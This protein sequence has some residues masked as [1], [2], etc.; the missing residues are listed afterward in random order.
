M[1]QVE[2][3]TADPSV[4]TDAAV[5]DAMVNVLM[6]VRDEED[7]VR[8]EAPM[9]ALHAARARNDDPRWNAVILSHVTVRLLTALD[10]V[11]DATALADA[12][13]RALAPFTPPAPT[14][15]NEEVKTLEALIP[16]GV[17][18]EKLSPE[19]VR[20]LPIGHLAAMLGERKEADF[21]AD[22]IKCDLT[23]ALTWLDPG[24]AALGGPVISEEFNASRPVV[25]ARAAAEV[26]RWCHG[27]L[28]ESGRQASW[29]F[30][31]V[32]RLLASAW[33]LVACPSA[34]W[35][36]R[37]LVHSAGR[38]MR[39]ALGFGADEDLLDES[40]FKRDGRPLMLVGPSHPLNIHR[41]WY[42]QTLIGYS[43]REAGQQV[44]RK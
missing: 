17:E 44:G 4:V 27:Q 25:W 34:N 12:R 3:A 38:G 23:A 16:P 33:T 2:Q 11:P 8:L 9:R 32:G 40:T 41:D 21:D 6:C 15:T 22:L 31:G 1:R 28:C 36:S 37:D 18:A 14:F 35:G 43:R 5:A 13:I 42:H 30:E 26:D 29:T 39:H 24:A 10:E 7:T 20:A 19:Q